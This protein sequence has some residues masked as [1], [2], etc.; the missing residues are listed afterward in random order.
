MEVRLTGGV[1]GVDNKSIEFKFTSVL[2][3]WM[4]EGAARFWRSSLQA[5]RI[6]YAEGS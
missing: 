2:M 1:R 3:E 4:G 5:P 6:E